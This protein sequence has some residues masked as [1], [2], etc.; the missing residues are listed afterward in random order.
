MQTL[1]DPPHFKIWPYLI[2][3]SFLFLKIFPRCYIPIFDGLVLI[4]R[5][6]D[7]ADDDRKAIVRSD[8]DGSEIEITFENFCGNSS[9]LQGFC[10]SVTICTIITILL[11]FYINCS[12]LQAWLVKT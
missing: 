5:E 7:D 11:P 9:F 6:E 10:V 4:Q 2:S 8:P 12:C 1:D 3:F